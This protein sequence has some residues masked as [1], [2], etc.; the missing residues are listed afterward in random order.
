[1]MCTPLTNQN[2]HRYIASATVFWVTKSI[3]LELKK[4]N[5][6]KVSMLLKRSSEQETRHRYIFNRCIKKDTK[7]AIG[8]IF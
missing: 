1:M 6:S 5:Y 7:N 2:A 3:I 8:M 4:H